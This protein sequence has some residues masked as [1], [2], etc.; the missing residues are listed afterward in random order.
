MNITFDELRRIKHQLPTGSVSKIAAELEIEEQTVRN[1]FGAKKYQNGEVVGCHI[2][3]GPGG[4]I[5]HLDDDQIL[6][7]AKRILAEAQAV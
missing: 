1:Y 6:N 3:P 4:G 7:I 5:V 2:E